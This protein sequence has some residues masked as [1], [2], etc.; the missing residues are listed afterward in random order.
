MEEHSDARNQ[1]LQEEWR[2]LLREE[3]ELRASIAHHQSAI[4]TEQDRLKE[5]QDFKAVFRSFYFGEGHA[6]RPQNVFE[7]GGP[8]L[9][10]LE[11]LKG[12]EGYQTAL[13]ALGMASADGYVHGRTAGQWLI[14]AGIL[15][16]LSVNEARIRLSKFMSRSRE[17]ERVEGKRGWFRYLPT[18][19]PENGADAPLQNNK[20][21]L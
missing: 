7:P 13:R 17:W 2:E 9:L 1:R 14:D 11:D 6:N 3:T 10:P 16:G 4:A 21:D 19:G 12:L 20:V 5:I 15:E 18:T 8:C